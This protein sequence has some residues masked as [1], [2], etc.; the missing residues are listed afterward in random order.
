[1]TETCTLN[2]LIRYIYHETNSE[3][4]DEIECALL[5]NEPLYEIYLTLKELRKEMDELSIEAPEK[6]MENIF[7]YARENIHVL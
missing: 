7:Q 1:M 2:D 4:S 6:I 5:I 3:E